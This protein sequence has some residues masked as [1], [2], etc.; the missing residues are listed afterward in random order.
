MKLCV[1]VC[2][3]CLGH[4]NSLKIMKLKTITNAA[5][6]LIALYVII[7]INLISRV[8]NREYGSSKMKVVY[9]IKVVIWDT[10]V[11]KYFVDGVMRV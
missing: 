2:S 1:G 4:C 8:I 10:S 5:E 3:Q 11:I 7:H 9:A 6:C